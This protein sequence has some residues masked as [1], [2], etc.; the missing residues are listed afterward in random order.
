MVPVALVG[1]I[2]ETIGS[3]NPGIFIV[4][5]NILLLCS[6]KLGIVPIETKDEEK[7][8]FMVLYFVYINSDYKSVT[9]LQTMEHAVLLHRDSMSILP[10]PTVRFIG[11]RKLLHPFSLLTDSAFKEHSSHIP[12]TTFILPSGRHRFESM[13]YLFPSGFIHFEGQKLIG[14]I[15]VCCIGR[16]SPVVMGTNTSTANGTAGATPLF[17]DSFESF[18]NS[19]EFI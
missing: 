16:F 10:F 3:S 15:D 5:K 1:T 18:S 11:V 7:E 8:S 4:V 9:K 2:E 19:Y 6:K 13:N 14:S 12:I 17:Y